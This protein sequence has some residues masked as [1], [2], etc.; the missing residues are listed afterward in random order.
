MGNNYLPVCPGDVKIYQDS[1][2]IDSV[3]TEGVQKVLMSGHP[4]GKLQ[5][6][7]V[8]QPLSLQVKKV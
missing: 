5:T 1:G 4:L 2:G 7:S 8:P 6:F 3:Y